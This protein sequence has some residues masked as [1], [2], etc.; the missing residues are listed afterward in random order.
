MT[1][2]LVRRLINMIPLILGITFLSFLVMS[3]V[4]GDFL[5]QMRMNPAISPEVIRQMQA[6]FGLD[7][8]LLVRYFKWLWAVLHLN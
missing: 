1:R 2:F 7:Q 8:P 4:P 3:L 5:S 6:Q